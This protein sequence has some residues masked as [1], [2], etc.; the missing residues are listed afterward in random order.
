MMKGRMLAA[1]TSD[2][3]GLST[4]LQLQKQGLLLNAAEGCMQGLTAASHKSSCM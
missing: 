3:H 4:L 2:Q 1:L